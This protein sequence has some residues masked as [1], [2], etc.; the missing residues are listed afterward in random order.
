[1]EFQWFFI[2]LSVLPG[3]HLAIKAHLF[4]N[5]NYDSYTLCELKLSF[6]LIP[7]STVTFVFMDSNG[8][9]I[10]RGIASLFFR[11]DVWR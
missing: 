11:E 6:C 5:L 10:V 4:P 1:V 2:E 7:P 3:K 9:A 8:Y